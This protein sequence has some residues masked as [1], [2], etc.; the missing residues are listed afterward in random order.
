M[1]IGVVAAEAAFATFARSVDMADL[2]DGEELDLE[3][4]IGRAEWPVFS[5]V[6]DTLAAAEPG[7]PRTLDERRSDA[8]RDLARICL[9]VKG[10]PAA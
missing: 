7:D 5:L 10:V 4:Q 1:R 6:L 3:G 8:L 2:A 9:A